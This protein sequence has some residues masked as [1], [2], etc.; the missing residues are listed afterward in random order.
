MLSMKAAAPGSWRLKQSARLRMGAL[1]KRQSC[2]SQPQ[3]NLLHAL[4]LPGRRRV[5]PIGQLFY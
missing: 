5:C 2:R 4:L 3:Q 1:F